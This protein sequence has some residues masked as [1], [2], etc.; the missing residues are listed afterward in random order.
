M[1][2]IMTERPPPGRLF[3]LLALLLA[4]ATPA[5]AAPRDDVP[6]SERRDVAARP[7][8]DDATREGAEAKPDP[9]GE[10]PADPAAAKQR[11]RSKEPTCFGKEA[12]SNDHSGKIQGTDGDDVFIGDDKANTIDAGTG[13]FDRICGGGGNDHIN[14]A[15]TD[16]VL[17]QGGPGDDDLS[18]GFVHSVLLGGTGNDTLRSRL[19]FGVSLLVGEQGDD[20]LRGSGYDTCQQ[21]GQDDPVAC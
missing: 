1:H 6:A 11:R 2:R 17:A 4:V 16:I 18:S 12:T 19:D 14:A 10:R 8:P 3:L 5:L 7:A 15:I 20:D 21:D 13:G 9:A